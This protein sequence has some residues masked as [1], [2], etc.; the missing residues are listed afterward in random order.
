MSLQFALPRLSM[1]ARSTVWMP[2]AAVTLFMAAYLPLAAQ[3][4]KLALPVQPAS[5]VATSSTAAPSPVTP[6]T[7]TPTAASTGGSAPTCT[8]IGFPSPAPVALASQPNGLTEQND[9]PATYQ[10]YGHTAT[11]LVSQIQHCAPG[12]AG[13]T[14]AEFTAETTYQLNWQYD[15]AMSASGCS[16]SNVRVG[17]HTIITLP[18]WQP[19]SRA[20]SELPSKWQSFIT[21]LT[22][23]EQGH[24]GLD[25]QYA[26][27]LVSD[28]QH[29][30]NVDCSLLNSSVNALIQHD[31]QALA[32]ANNT[33][34]SQTNHGATQ[35]AVLPR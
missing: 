28:L 20:N 4:L 17:I 30:Q 1:Q 14:P 9:N 10:I 12:A 24:V 25:H 26:T 5:L 13:S 2:A 32:T 23:H 27:Q 16:L 29:V 34:D 8:P 7:I 19:D 11:D 18:Y 6:P 33:Y 22:T 31:T 21:A 15:V 35:G 3:S